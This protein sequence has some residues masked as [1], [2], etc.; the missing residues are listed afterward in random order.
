MVGPGWSHYVLDKRLEEKMNQLKRESGIMT[1]RNI[2]SGTY[3]CVII[4]ESGKIVK[5]KKFLLSNI[6]EKLRTVNLFEETV[7]VYSSRV[8]K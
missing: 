7:R 6:C 5:K 4:G 2:I 1:K 3:M 8:I